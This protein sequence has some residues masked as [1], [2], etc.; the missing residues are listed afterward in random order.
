MSYDIRKP[1]WI[2]WFTT[3]WS[4]EAPCLVKMIILALLKNTNATFI[5]FRVHSPNVF[6]SEPLYWLLASNNDEREKLNTIITISQFGCLCSYCLRGESVFIGECEYRQ[7]L[8]NK[9]IRSVYIF[10]RNHFVALLCYYNYSR[11]SQISRHC[12]Y[13][14]TWHI[15]KIC[16]SIWE[17]LSVVYGSH[18]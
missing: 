17:S 13:R 14:Y 2:A 1:C 11:F 7:Q 15:C 9:F 18:Q 16:V 5:S 10:C 8:L 6:V 3:F 4:C 12:Q